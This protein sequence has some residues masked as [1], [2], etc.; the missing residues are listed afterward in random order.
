MTY[1]P[2]CC[3]HICDTKCTYED[4]AVQ[5]ARWFLL[6]LQFVGPKPCKSFFV[7][8]RH[9]NAVSLKLHWTACWKKM[10]LRPLTLNGNFILQIKTFTNSVFVV[11]PNYFI[12]GSIQALCVFIQTRVWFLNSFTEWGL[13]PYQNYLQ[14][15]ADV[16]QELH[17]HCHLF[18]HCWN[19]TSKLLHIHTC[20]GN[21][22]SSDW[23]GGGGTTT[24][25]TVWSLRTTS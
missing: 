21:G 1:I 8:T 15:H 2:R 5:P 18:V 19:P 7:L 17:R 3:F 22:Q 6:A 13:W 9:V 23:E 12:S 14:K 11:F 4:T 24:I 10:R 25:D 20:S 16:V